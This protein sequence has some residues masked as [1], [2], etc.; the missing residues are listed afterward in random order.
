MNS[1]KPWTLRHEVFLDVDAQTEEHR[2]FKGTRGGLLLARIV[3]PV[4]VHIAWDTEQFQGC[5]II[6]H[7]RRRRW[8]K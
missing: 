7:I 8:S 2:L 6:N 5:R 3:V 4:G 1:P